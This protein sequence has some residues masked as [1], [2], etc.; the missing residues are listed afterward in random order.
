ML[1][2]FAGRA[3]EQDTERLIIDARVSNLHFLPPPL[4]VSLVI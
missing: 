3:A 1:V 2:F 4:G